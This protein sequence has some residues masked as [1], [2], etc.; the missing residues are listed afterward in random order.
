[1]C[2]KVVLV[3][4]CPCE[5]LQNTS[6]LH[7]VTDGPNQ[8]SRVTFAFYQVVLGAESVCSQGEVLILFGIKDDKGDH[9]GCDSGW[10]QSVCALAFFEA[11]IEQ[12]CVERF[13]DETLQSGLHIMDPGDVERNGSRRLKQGCD[14]VG[15]RVVDQQNPKG[16]LVGLQFGP[17]D[18]GPHPILARLSHS[19]PIPLRVSSDDGSQGMSIGVCFMHQQGKVW[20]DAPMGCCDPDSTF[21]WLGFRGLDQSRLNDASEQALGVVQFIIH[22]ADTAFLADS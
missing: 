4:T 5:V 8:E 1:M 2:G 7:R 13:I 3:L 22:D 12:D 19:A 21:G 10:S 17:A 11:Q 20:P 14:F 18:F 9:V 15:I 16:S 6:P